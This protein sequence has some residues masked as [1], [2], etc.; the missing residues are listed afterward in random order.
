M[1]TFLY[2]LAPKS[3]APQPK[4]IGLKPATT[5]VPT[6]KLQLLKQSRLQRP[7]A[8]KPAETDVKKGPL[9]AFA[10]P[11]KVETQGV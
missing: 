6:S 8:A 4:E 10:P 3:S 7:A 11:A 2:H 5:A 9:K 1:F